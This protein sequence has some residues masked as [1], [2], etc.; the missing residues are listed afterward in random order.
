MSPLL[1]Y[2]EG[3]APTEPFA[4]CAALR[5]VIFRCRNNEGELLA[6]GHN[7]RASHPNYF[8]V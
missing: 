4:P 3:E 7:P 1:V 5:I 8:P 6:L 2:G